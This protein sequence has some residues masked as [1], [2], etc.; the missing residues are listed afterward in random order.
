MRAAFTLLAFAAAVF[1]ASA[2][3]AQWPT[4]ASIRVDEPPATSQV[5]STEEGEW[6]GEAPWGE[7]IVDEYGGGYGYESVG[8]YCGDCGMG[9]PCDSV[10]GPHFSAKPE[11]LLWW[12]QSMNV[13]KLV[14]TSPTGTAREDAGVLGPGFADTAT[15]TTL[16]GGGRADNSTFA[17]GGRIAL[18]WWTDA[19]ETLGIVGNFFMLQDADFSYSATSGGTPILARPFFNV[20]PLVGDPTQAASVLAYPAELAGSINIRGTS[21]L[22]GAEA[23]LS[24]NWFGWNQNR[25]DVSYGYRMLRL[26]ELLQINDALEFLQDDGFV[27]AGTT[28]DSLDEFETRNIFHG[29]QL[30]VDWRRGGG[31]FTTDVGLKLALGN[32]NQ[33]AK[34]AGQSTTSVPGGGSATSA[35]GLLALPT[36]IGEYERNRFSA[37]LDFRLGCGW[38]WTPRSK[39]TFAYTLTYVNHVLRPGDQISLNVND[40]QLGGGTLTGTAAPLFAFNETDFWAQGVNVGWEYRR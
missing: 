34:I 2:A 29:G 3:H 13:P 1:A 15:T 27:T 9:F 4:P 18:G 25:I 19:D 8:P 14:T 35:G 39:I 21:E 37:L 10:C 24:E 40:S 16:F 12:L 11:A 22:Y 33:R 20:A 5:V 6:V 38:N 28:I 32:M 7:T 26:N 17:A 23:Y 36:N 30:G 31:R